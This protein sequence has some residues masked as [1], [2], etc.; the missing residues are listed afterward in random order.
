M[1]LPWFF[2]GLALAVAALVAR[3]AAVRGIVGGRSELWWMYY[4]PNIGIALW[5]LIGIGVPLLRDAPALGAFVVAMIGGYLAL[6]VGMTARRA[7]R[8]RV[9]NDEMMVG[10]AA[11]DALAMTGFLLLLAIGGCIVLVIAAATGHLT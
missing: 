1:N 4:A 8:P 5:I 3:R 9:P 11:E 10:D 7:A 6:I 2:G